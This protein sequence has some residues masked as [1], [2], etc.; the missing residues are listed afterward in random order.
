[1]IGKKWFW[2][3]GSLVHVVY[4]SS[5]ER[6]VMMCRKFVEGT[7]TDVRPFGFPCQRCANASES[8]PKIAG[9]KKRERDEPKEPGIRIICQYK[10]RN[11]RKGRKCR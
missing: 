8:F 9:G 7:V 11:M 6:H 1:M 4:E 5:G 3:C 2:T 10:L